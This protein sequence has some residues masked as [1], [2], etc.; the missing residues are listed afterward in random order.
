[1]VLSHSKLW[2]YQKVNYGIIK[3]LIIVLS[4]SNGIIKQ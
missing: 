2:Y 3:K 1:M 4:N